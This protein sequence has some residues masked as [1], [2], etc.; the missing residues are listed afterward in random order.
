MAQP[1]PA[2]QPDGEAPTM[3]GAAGAACRE[4]VSRWN[5]RVAGRVR[6]GPGGDP[7]GQGRQRAGPGGAGCAR[8]RCGGPGR[9]SLG[10]GRE[11][12]AAAL[13]EGGGKGVGRLRGTGPKLGSVEREL[14]WDSRGTR[15]WVLPLGRM[16]I[17]NLLYSLRGKKKKS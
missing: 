7:A 14:P 9:P 2:S 13:A 12:P 11:A 17:G 8:R 5:L 4:P 3:A 15:T 1:G 6:A 16:G 10:R